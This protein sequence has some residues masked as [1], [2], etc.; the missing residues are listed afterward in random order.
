MLHTLVMNGREE[1][2]YH[3]RNDTVTSA[4][5]RPSRTFIY[6]FSRL[7][8]TTFILLRFTSRF[9]GPIMWFPLPSL[10]LCKTFV[11]SFNLCES[12]ESPCLAHIQQ[13]PTLIYL[14]VF[15][16][17]PVALD[18]EKVQIDSPKL[19]FYNRIQRRT[20]VGQ[21]YE[22]P[23]FNYGNTPKRKWSAS[24]ELCDRPCNAWT[25]RLVL[26]G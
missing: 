24:H 8:L 19:G 5:P 14:H 6:R 4:I 17:Q 12:H 16:G 21:R 2:L 26:K 23:G 20:T 22:R 10:Q 13:H 3:D 15:T 11:S 7:F 1:D 9:F 18:L 25:H